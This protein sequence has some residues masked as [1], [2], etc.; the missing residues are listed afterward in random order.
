MQ[1]ILKDSNKTIRDNGIFSGTY[2]KELKTDC[3]KDYEP[4]VNGDANVATV[5][6]VKGKLY[7]TINNIVS[8]NKFNSFI[9][10]L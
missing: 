5:F 4:M 6:F 1:L 8:T 7:Q 10:W 2:S 3:I 9:F